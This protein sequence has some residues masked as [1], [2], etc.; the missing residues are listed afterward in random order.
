ML[1]SWAASSGTLARAHPVLTVLLMLLVARLLW[2]YVAFL[3]RKVA[4]RVTGGREVVVTNESTKTVFLRLF[5]LHMRKPAG[6]AALR[7][8]VVV[9]LP[10][11]TATLAV[12]RAS[13]ASEPALGW[14]LSKSE[15]QTTH[16]GR[17][18]FQW[19]SLGV[20]VSFAQ[21]QIHFLLVHPVLSRKPGAVSLVTKMEK[22]LTSYVD[23]PVKKHSSDTILHV[24]TG[25]DATPA[26]RKARTMRGLSNE[27]R[28][29]RTARR[30]RVTAA[31]RELLRD[32][33]VGYCNVAMLSSGGGARSMVAGAG[34]MD[35]LLREG[36]MG[37]VSYV[38]GSSGSCWWL[39]Q[40]MQQCRQGGSLAACVE[41]TRVSMRERSRAPLFGALKEQGA[42]LAKQLALK[43]A[44]NQSV[45][46]VDVYGTVIGSRFDVPPTLSSQAACLSDGALP[47][48]VYHVAILDK[49]EQRVVSEEMT[50]FAV[51][52]KGVR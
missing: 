20:G 33:S 45:S 29:W 3:F 27:E 40:F 14:A 18:P 39:A 48:P 6:A 31:L 8:R 50:P 7:E 25:G 52:F 5:L 15:L 11:E 36:I 22:A 9:L 37:G 12:P 19:R 35:G 28:A 32:D 23:E 49:V 44:Y 51:T 1:R 30:V 43:V 17:I 24:S 10:G 21:Q 38:M 42:L 16:S 26:G 2:P 46:L 34:A 41:R 13:W 4:L 47:L